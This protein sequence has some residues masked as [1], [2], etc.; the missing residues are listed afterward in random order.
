MLYLVLAPCKLFGG[1]QRFGET[2][3]LHLQ[4][5]CDDVGKWK[6]SYRIVRCEGWG[7]GPVRDEEWGEQVSGSFL[8]S[9]IATS[10]LKMEIVC[11]SETLASTDESTRRQNP[12][13]YHPDRRENVRS[14][15]T[16][17]FYRTVKRN[18]DIAMMME[19]A[20]RAFSSIMTSM[21]CV[22]S[23]CVT[24]I[25]PVIRHLVREISPPHML[26]I[27]DS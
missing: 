18:S 12:E 5:W 20:N 1:C 23:R 3:Y 10:A 2:Y 26:V 15:N 14:Q 13:E 22:H 6:D 11:F 21:S 27:G 4:G 16:L 24:V 25:R 19:Q 17:L 8:T 9:S 7:S